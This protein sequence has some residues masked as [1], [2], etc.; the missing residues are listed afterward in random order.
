MKVIL[1]DVL[2][3]SYVKFKIKLKKYFYRQILLTTSQFLF[4]LNEKAIQKHLDLI[5]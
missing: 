1:I 4:P 2:I 5:A 3:F